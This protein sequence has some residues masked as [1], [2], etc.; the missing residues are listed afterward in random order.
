MWYALLADLVVAVHVAY[1]AYVVLGEL[2]ILVGALCRWAWVRHPWFRLT[3]LAAIAVVAFEAVCDIRCPLTVWEDWLR[4]RAGQDV[5]EGTF[6]GRFL[7]DLLF[8]N[9]P[10]WVFTSAYVGFAVLV[11]ATLVLVPMRR[12]PTAEPGAPLGVG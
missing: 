12:H 6:I 4:S 2:A 11:A 8:Y 7:H 9:A 10:P 3:H 5:A 1:V